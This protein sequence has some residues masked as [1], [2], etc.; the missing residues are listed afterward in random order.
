MTDD[1]Y[2]VCEREERLEPDFL[3]ALS[4]LQLQPILQRLRNVGEH[5]L[6]VVPATTGPQTPE[7]SSVVVS[8]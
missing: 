6:P 1:Q 8:T 7:T 2:I 5:V 3:Y 4:V